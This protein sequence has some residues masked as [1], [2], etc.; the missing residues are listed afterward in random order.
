[1]LFLQKNFSLKAFSLELIIDMTFTA[2]PVLSV[3]EGGGVNH[4]VVRARLSTDGAGDLSANH[5]ILRTESSLLQNQERTIQFGY[6]RT[7]IN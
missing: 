5:V 6:C 3:R 7:G 1:M 2:E 4:R